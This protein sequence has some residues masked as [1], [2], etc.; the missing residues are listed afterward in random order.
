MS[1]SKTYLLPLVD[2]RAQEIRFALGGVRS[3]REVSLGQ[4][5]CLGVLG[6]RL[7]S[8][9]LDV[10]VSEFLIEAQNGVKK[11]VTLFERRTLSSSGISG[12][13]VDSSNAMSMMT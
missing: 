8:C 4:I 13:L 1:S 12:A 11:V 6:G 9:I 2:L 10:T 5:Q 7:S 3:H